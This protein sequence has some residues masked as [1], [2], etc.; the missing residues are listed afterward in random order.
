MR[1]G[2]TMSIS[3]PTVSSACI[4]VPGTYRHSRNIWEMNEWM[5]FSSNYLALLRHTEL[6]SNLNPKPLSCTPWLNLVF[7]FPFSTTTSVHKELHFMTQ[8]QASFCLVKTTLVPDFVT[9]HACYSFQFLPSSDVISIS[10]MFSFKSL[11]AMKTQ[12]CSLP[13]QISP[14]W[15]ESFNHHSVPSR[16]GASPPDH[17]V[18]GRHF[19]SLPARILCKILL[20][21]LDAFLNFRMPWPQYPTQERNEVILPCLVLSEPTLASSDHY[22][23]FFRFT[24][25]S[26]VA[27]WDLKVNTA[28]WQSWREKPVPGLL[29]EASR[30]KRF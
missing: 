27:K 23:R 15:H 17:N 1:L 7:P 30:K 3:F 5:S 26:T 28:L 9:V 19:S 22:L 13:Q 4:K 6:T 11:I 18:T 16:S 25:S 14:A 24:S 10:S 2:T 20:I 8:M 29:K 21:E 12:P